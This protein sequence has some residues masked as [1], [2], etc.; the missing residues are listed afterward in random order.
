[1]RLR[2]VST[3]PG[4]L[5]QNARGASFGFAIEG[6]TMSD[7]DSANETL[8]ESTDQAASGAPMSGWAVGD[9]FSADEIFHRV[10]ATA[11]E[12][13]ATGT[14]ELLFSGLAAGFAIT[15]TF[16]GHAAVTEYFPTNEPIAALLYPVGFVYI[17]L[18]RYQLYTE[19]TLPPVALVL[20]RLAS[21]PL[22]ARVWGLVLFGNLV[23]ACIGAFVLANSHVLTTEAMRVGAGFASHGVELP[24]WDVFWKAIFAGWIVGSIVWLDHA[25]RDT[26]ARF[27]LIYIAFYTI[28]ATE[29]YHVV[30]AA[31]DAF[32]YVFYT[33]AGLFHTFYEF[34]LP[35][36][37]GNTIGGV[38]LVT[39]VNYA[40]IE[41]RRIPEVREL[42]LRE[43]LFSR[44]GG[45]TDEVQFEEE[46][47]SRTD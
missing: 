2:W 27:F 44:R 9:R 28:S 34:W 11:D 12:E 25:S 47:E 4:I 10:L 38:V 14:M 46:V 31:C 7:G 3:P 45:S 35:V 22:L 23:G 6:G 40:Q 24:W 21:L 41:D 16:V 5:P 33:G 13:V 37:L 26:I 17:I 42:S 20:A 8:E 39:L 15:I 1:V 32:F 29:L 30:T 19:N 18:G 36:L 43:V